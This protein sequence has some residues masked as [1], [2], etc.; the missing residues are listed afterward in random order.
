MS[1]FEN[2][3][4]EDREYVL[5]L[6]YHLA[7][8]S[9][10]G[11]LCDILTEFDFLEYKVFAAKVQ[12]LIEDYDFALKPNI[13]FSEDKK[14][15]LRLIQGAIRLSAH[16]LAEEKTQLAGQ[17]L[18]RLMSFESP[19]IQAMLERSKQEQ[20]TWLR[21]LTPSLISPGTALLRTITGGTD[22]EDIIPLTLG[23]QQV[24]SHQE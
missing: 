22:S 20:K 12:P 2:L 11:D 5:N 9:M 13:E 23:G 6:P 4:P 15:S 3:S 14:E 24:I 19:E 10:T 8:A 1:E 17:L 21:P 16:I 18:G 7:Q